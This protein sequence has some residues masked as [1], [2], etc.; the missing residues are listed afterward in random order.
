MTR[1]YDFIKYLGLK[2]PVNLR[3]ITRKNRWAD[4]EY[5]AEYSDKTGKLKEH[6]ITVYFKNNSRE[7]DTLIAHELIHAWQEEHKK[8]ETHG[9]YFI[10][11]A[12]KMEKDFGLTEIYIEGIDLE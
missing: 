2:K 6:K 1:L 8:T 5:E 4:A 9:E 11:Y 12:R 10:K 3:I 7:L